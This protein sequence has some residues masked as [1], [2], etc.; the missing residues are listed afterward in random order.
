MSQ[1][2]ENR[3]ADNTGYWELSWSAPRY[4]CCQTLKVKQ[5]KWLKWHNRRCIIHLPIACR[6]SI[7][8]SRSVLMRDWALWNST[9]AAAAILPPL[10]GLPRS[11][12]SIHSLARHRKYNLITSSSLSSSPHIQFIYFFPHKIYILEMLWRVL[13]N[14]F[15]SCNSSCIWKIWQNYGWSF[16]LSSWWHLTANLAR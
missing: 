9:T 15:K 3:L 2:Q 12:I 13:H 8:A 6:I 14:I 1:Q 11:H 7:D 4:A 5:S 16:I 10:L